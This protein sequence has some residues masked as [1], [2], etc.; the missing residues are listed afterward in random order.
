MSAKPDRKAAA[1]HVLPAI[2]SYSHT[3]EVG[4]PFYDGH[5][6]LRFPDG[7]NVANGQWGRRSVV[8]AYGRNREI[9]GRD[10]HLVFRSVKACIEGPF[11]SRFL[12]GAPAPIVKH[13]L[14]HVEHLHIYSAWSHDAAAGMNVSVP[15]W[16]RAGVCRGYGRLM[17][18]YAQLVE[19]GAELAL[20]S[21][22]LE[23]PLMLGEFYASVT[24]RAILAKI[25]RIA[26]SESHTCTERELTPFLR[27]LPNLAH[28]PKLT[29]WFN[30]RNID[31]A[32]GEP[33]VDVQLV[34]HG[35]FLANLNKK[36]R[37]ESIRINV[38]GPGNMTEMYTWLRKCCDTDRALKHL[39]IVLPSGFYSDEDEIVEVNRIHAAHAPHFASITS[40]TYDLVPADAEPDDCLYCPV[41]HHLI[42]PFA[43]LRTLF[44]T[45]PLYNITG[46][47]ALPRLRELHCTEV[48]E[49]ATLCAELLSHRPPALECLAL[50][51]RRA[52]FVR[53][54]F[55]VRQLLHE[56]IYPASPARSA[57]LRHLA[58][59][60]A[61]HAT[62]NAA[63]RVGGDDF[64]HIHDDVQFRSSSKPKKQ[65]QVSGR[66]RKHFERAIVDE[67]EAI[68]SSN[69]I[70]ARKWYSS[71]DIEFVHSVLAPEAYL[72]ATGKKA[73]ESIVC[74][75]EKNNSW[76]IALGENSHSFDVES[77]FPHFALPRAV[78]M[79]TSVESL[80]S[81]IKLYISKD[82]EDDDPDAPSDD[83]DEDEDALF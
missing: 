37:L 13:F 55:Y 30:L 51:M 29:V 44:L 42:P 59:S 68:S 40:F 52:G 45:G 31:S 2:L 25:T 58:L 5:F 10:I 54:Q 46:F 32:V 48:V 12:F 6:T 60:D 41:N 20:R 23:V 61:R 77:C 43:N 80:N 47:E 28:M 8:A 4:H 63:R 57:P 18:F 81:N 14:S 82:Q 72:R 83:F 66:K 65:Q 75:H 21:I 36:T 38:D 9:T 35:N 22:T 79:N 71:I 19:E 15:G 7:A 49:V 17:Q 39:E 11:V 76:Y 26:D 78:D 27:S 16:A 67:F 70:S 74:N 34:R 62:D 50:H 1:F 24:P 53:D 64:V 56:M 73:V 33:D 3:V 69:N